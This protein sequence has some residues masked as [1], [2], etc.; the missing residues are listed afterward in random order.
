MPL[1]HAKLDKITDALVAMND[2]V[3]AYCARADASKED[4][5]LAKM[6]KTVDVVSKFHRAVN[7][8]ISPTSW[9]DYVSEL[10][11]MGADRSSLEAMKRIGRFDLSGGNVRFGG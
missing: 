1:D 6:R 4:P 9:S 11:K 5:D 2:R 10:T 3:D 7:S 8:K